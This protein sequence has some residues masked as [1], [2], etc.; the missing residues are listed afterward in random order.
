MSADPE[1]EEGVPA[2]EL[3]LCEGGDEGSDFRTQ[4]DPSAPLQRN[5]ITERKGAIDI[6]CTGADV[7]HG[8]LKDG[9]GPATLIVYSTLR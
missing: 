1:I 2:F 8:Y 4:N 7:I 5:N 9:E 6:R 3:G